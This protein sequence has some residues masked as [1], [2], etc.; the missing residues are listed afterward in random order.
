[1]FHTRLRCP[2]SSFSTLG[3]GNC[4]WAKA[5]ARSGDHP[6]PSHC[7]KIVTNPALP[8]PPQAHIPVAEH[9]DRFRWYPSHRGLRFFLRDIPSRFVVRGG[10]RGLLPRQRSRTTA[11]PQIRKTSRPDHESQRHVCIR[12]AYLGG[13]D[14]FPSQSLIS[15]RSSSGLSHLRSSRERPRSMK[16][17][18]PLS[19][20]EC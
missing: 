14:H 8:K 11:P 19:F 20:V 15:I 7:C 4:P 10:R 17:L 18:M 2:R 1:M 16:I 6:R 13:M 9:L 5:H 12:D 3:P